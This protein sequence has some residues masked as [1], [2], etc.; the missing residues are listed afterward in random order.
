L[1]K[2][3]AVAIVLCCITLAAQEFSGP[4]GMSEFVTVEQL[5]KAFDGLDKGQ[6]DEVLKYRLKREQFDD[7]LRNRMIAE[8]AYSDALDRATDIWYANEGE[9]QKIPQTLW[10][11]LREMDKYEFRHATPGK[12]TLS[13]SKRPPITGG[14]R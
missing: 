12:E 4:V 2:G 8:A 5:E 10:D 13:T 3:F 7:W 14:S 6:K 1:K 11:K 9:W